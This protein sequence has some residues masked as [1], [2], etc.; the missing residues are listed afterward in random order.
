MSE[1]VVFE[2][3]PRFVWYLSFF[4]LGLLI[5]SAFSC[6]FSMF[7][8]GISDFLKFNQ[9]FDLGFQTLILIDFIFFIFIVLLW[10][11]IEKKNYE[12]TEYKVYKDRLEFEEGFI[13][14]K[15][16][17]IKTADIKE[18]HFEQSFLQRV[19]GVGT[20]RIVTAANS[21]NGSYSGIFIRDI[22]NARYAYTKI[23]DIYESI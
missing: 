4:P 9:V 14:H 6:F 18:V 15:Y 17:T 8:W 16:T 7:T 20:I 3:K 1:E 13:N 5:A 12:V 23:K 19:A 10:L 11:F 2:A 21:S 22:D